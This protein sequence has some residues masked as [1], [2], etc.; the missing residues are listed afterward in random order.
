M[1]IDDEDKVACLILGASDEQNQRLFNALTTMP[2]DRRVV[3]GE[4]LPFI[5]RYVEAGGR[6]DVL[7]TGSRPPEHPNLLL[8]NADN[9]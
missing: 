2:A 3:I 5:V 7:P 6:L 4:P 9:R 1:K 8:L